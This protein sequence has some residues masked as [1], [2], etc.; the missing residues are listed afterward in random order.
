M[1]KGIAAATIAAIAALAPFSTAQA[2]SVAVRID[3]IGAAKCSQITTD[4]KTQPAVV[5]NSVV[6]WAYGYMTRRNIERGLRGQPQVDINATVSDQR[7]LQVI[8]S[9]CGDQP[10]ARIFQVVDALY[11]V[12]LEKGSL[13]S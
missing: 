13:V 6:H 9:F 8:L 2:D 10:E 1:L 12:L 4:I 5:A 11:E 3:G 7:L